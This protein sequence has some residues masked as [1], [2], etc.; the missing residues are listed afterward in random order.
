MYFQVLDDWHV[1]KYD[2]DQIYRHKFGP[3]HEDYLI[4]E[5]K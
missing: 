5:N 2:Q 1:V 3:A 4:K